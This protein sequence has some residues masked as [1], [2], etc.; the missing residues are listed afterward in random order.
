MCAQPCCRLLLVS[1]MP[2]ASRACC[3]RLLLWRDLWQAGSLRGAAAPPGRVPTPPLLPSPRGR[4]C[5]G[6]Y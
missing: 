6:L 5:D 4:A 3:C 2:R 1:G